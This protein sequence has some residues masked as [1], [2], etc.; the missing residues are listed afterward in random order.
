M[1]W[2]CDKY[3]RSPWLTPWSSLGSLELQ[4]WTIHKQIFQ[5]TKINT[6]VKPRWLKYELLKE[7]LSNWTRTWMASSG[8]SVPLWTISSR[9]SVRHIPIVDL[10]YSSNVAII[11]F[12]TICPYKF[13]AAQIIV[14]SKIRN[15]LT[16]RGIW[17]VSTKIKEVDESKTSIGDED[18]RIETVYRSP[19]TGEERDW[20]VNAEELPLVDCEGFCLLS[21]ENFWG[22]YTLDFAGDY[23]YRQR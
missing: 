17:K 13:R 19:A 22:F 4:S 12:P 11:Y 16:N 20:P 18:D 7:T 3:W 1:D 2:K 15:Y 8:L 5:A 14:E 21:G 6:V 10:L 9:V 23:I